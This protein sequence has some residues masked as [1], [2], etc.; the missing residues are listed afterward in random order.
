MDFISKIRRE[1]QPYFESACAWEI[2]DIASIP[3]LRQKLL[4]NRFPAPV[5]EA[6]AAKF[7]F[8][9][10]SVPSVFS[11]TRVKLRLFVP[12]N[13]G[14]SSGC[15]V[16]FR[17]S[18]FVIG[19]AWQHDG[20]CIELCTRTNSA[21]VSVDYRLA[22]EHP[23]PAAIEDCYSGLVWA[24]ANAESL[25]VRRRNLALAG[26]SAGGGLAVSAALL[27]RDRSGP[28][29]DLL[30]PLYPML[31]PENNRASNLNIIQPQVWD[32]QK[33]GMGWKAYLSDTLRSDLHTYKA[34]PA[35]ADTYRGLPPV[36]TYI[37]EFDA[38]RDEC[39]AFVQRL[40]EDDVPVDFH[41]FAGCFHSFEVSYPSAQI[42]KTATKMLAERILSAF[43]LP[44]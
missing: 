44:Q 14:P 28:K 22:P 33:N 10:V 42:S 39:L 11:D 12:A 24:D 6:T 41:L 9:E 26:A 30:L 5:A 8:S 35:Y 21:V 3:S 36:Y 1:L 16:F 2:D 20:F 4:Q 27:A 17:G 18:G 13:P 23:Y 19:S 40:C 25:G 32:G 31:E 15:I 37:G 29:I 34:A 7:R 43:E 38:L